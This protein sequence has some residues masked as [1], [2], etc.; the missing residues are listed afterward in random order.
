MDLR[1][2]APRQRSAV[3]RNGFCVEVW[4]PSWRERMW[5]RILRIVRRAGGLRGH[6]WTD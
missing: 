1:W 6:E 3:D 2:N 5:H 4:F